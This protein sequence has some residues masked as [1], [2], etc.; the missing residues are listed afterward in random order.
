M[1]H[2]YLI[3]LAAVMLLSLAACS[4][5]TAQTPTP[6]APPPG[7]PAAP[8]AS[9]SPA[10]GRQGI[11]T[12]STPTPVVPSNLEKM[13]PDVLGSYE[14]RI[15]FKQEV[16]AP[17]PAVES[18][19]VMQI[20]YRSQP[21]PAAYALQ[22]EDKLGDPEAGMRLVASGADNYMFNVDLDKWV[23]M[24][25]Q[26]DAANITGELLDPGLI[27]AES[28]AGLFTKENI[29][30]A[31][32]VVDGV[33]T[34]HYKA[35]EKQ[36]Q[37]MM[38]DP[39]DLQAGR[40]IVSG[41]A[42]FWVA[43]QGGYLKRYQ[44]QSVIADPTGRRMEQ[45]VRM[46]VTRENQTV[47]VALPAA[48]QVVDGSQVAGDPS[49]V[50]PDAAPRKEREAALKGLPAPPSGRPAT[51][52]EIAASRDAMENAFSSG[53]EPASV[54]VTNS[55]V[56]DVTKSYQTELPKLGWREEFVDTQSEPGKSAFA[57]FSN[58]QMTLMV[59]IVRPDASD[60]TIVKLEMQ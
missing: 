53:D 47:E 17:T 27:A 56:L 34:T 31:N 14:A 15:E 28:P 7:G 60:R 5:G 23:K 9:A 6:A 37:E 12:A 1:K 44:M 20:R 57:V 54:F 39:A 35:T 59:V 4:G 21:T 40:G 43:N 13:K 32:E 29:V 24:P 8:R 16:T 41:S 52:E 55:P 3:M 48:D 36:V 30:N 42:E 26:S 11:I 33:A 19:S 25:A 51:E 50:N 49:V 10:A 38:S 22:V 45:N 18:W 2:N 58:E 46:E